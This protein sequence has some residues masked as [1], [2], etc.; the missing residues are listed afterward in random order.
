MTPNDSDA[1]LFAAAQAG[2]LAKAEGAVAAGA[3][4]NSA[5]PY[6]VTPLLEAAGQGHL[7]MARYLIDQGAQIDYTG[8]SEGSPLTLV[9]YMGRVDFI[10]LFVAA[11]ANVNLAMPAGGETALHMAAVANQSAAAGALLDAGADANLHVKS[12]VATSMFDGGAKLWGETPLHYAAAY[13]DEEMIQAMLGARA[14]RKA[15]NAH[16]ETPM[17][18]AGHH[19]RPRS[20]RDLLK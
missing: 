19:K 16:G 13:G 18:Y 6:H 4:V 1:A 12:G 14:D 5:N 8:M 17:E 15:L 20:I 7:E 9:T 10:R 11:G 2:D 3:N